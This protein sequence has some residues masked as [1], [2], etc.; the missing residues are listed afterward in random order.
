MPM[1]ENPKLA[2]LKPF[3]GHW[4]TVGRHPL[5]PDTVFHGET[6]FEWIEN[7]ALL[8]MRT[9]MKEPG[10][11]AGVAIFGSDDESDR[12]TMLYFDERGVSRN[13]KSRAERNV[14]KWWRDSAHFSQRFTM[15]LAAD[16]RTMNGA[17]QYAKDD[18]DW[19]QDLKLLYTRVD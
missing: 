1:P 13:Y 6:T 12:L 16:G 18:A 19:E 9:S 3:V 11:P 5:M 2:P 10:I 17:G 15:T 4:S 14:W 8:L 7:G